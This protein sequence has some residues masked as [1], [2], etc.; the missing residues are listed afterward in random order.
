MVFTFTRVVNQALAHRFVEIDVIRSPCSVAA[1]RPR[2]GLRSAFLGTR[3]SVCVNVRLLCPRVL[4]L[5]AASKVS[6]ERSIQPDVV[7]LV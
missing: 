5:R 7:L 2:L 3:F 6:G 1:D 4:A